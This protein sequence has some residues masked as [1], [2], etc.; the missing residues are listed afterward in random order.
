MNHE[1]N[2]PF[3]N[4]NSHQKNGQANVN[5]YSW[6]SGAIHDNE[7]CEEVTHAECTAVA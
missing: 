3:S 6:D 1:R 2:I 5:P 4:T 7:Q